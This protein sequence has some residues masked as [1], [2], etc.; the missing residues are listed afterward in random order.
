MVFVMSPTMD[1]TKPTADP[2]LDALLRDLYGPLAKRH[3]ARY[4]SPHIPIHVILRAFQGRPLLVPDKR[5][6]AI[7]AGVLARGLVVFG[8]IRLF[9]YVA[10]CNHF[11]LEIQ[12]QPHEIPRFI[13]YLK[14]ELTKRWRPCIDWTDTI[15]RRGYISTALPT[16]QSQV[17]CFAYILS[18]GVKE[19]IVSR[20]E[21]WTGLHMAH[22]VVAGK[23]VKGEWVDGTRLGKALWKEKQKPEH[24]RRQP[25]LEKYTT[26]D[27]LELSPLPAWSG[28]SETERCAE[29]AVLVAQIVADG[30][31][32][33][34]GEPPLGM[35]HARS[36]PQELR[37]PLPA[38]PW[39]EERR[40]FICWADPNAPET[41]AYLQDY[42]EFQLAYREASNA[43]L[44]GDRDAAFP[45]GAFKP[46][47]FEPFPGAEADFAA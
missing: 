41:K 27:P 15:W 47:V 13:A 40:G 28:L 46:V 31:A 17:R 19:K 4:H 12:G 7:A 6:K 21:E 26:R 43:Y 44:K 11:H 36:L 22:Q 39:F 1:H 5:F 9:A 3:H 18:H 20:P 33:R 35:E 2:E 14:R 25:D 10:L 45:P 34:G 24:K 8:S 16:A 38:P 42:W 29:I 32:A 30:E 37:M 23:T